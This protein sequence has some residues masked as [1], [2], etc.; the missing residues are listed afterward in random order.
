MI[1]NIKVGNI[2]ECLN[3]GKLFRLKQILLNEYQEGIECP[4]CKKAYDIHAYH[5]YGKE[6]KIEDVLDPGFDIGN[7]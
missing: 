6:Q 5:L 7:W 1:K 3:C 2:L 4:H